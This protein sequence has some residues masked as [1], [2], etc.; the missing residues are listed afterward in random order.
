MDNSFASGESDPLAGTW[1]MRF[2]FPLYCYSRD[3]NNFILNQGFIAY[4]KTLVLSL[5]WIAWLQT[6]WNKYFE[7]WRVLDS[8][9]T[10]L[11]A[12]TATP[13]LSISC[14]FLTKTCSMNL[15]QP[16]VIKTQLLLDVCKKFTPGASLYLMCCFV[17]SVKRHEPFLL[18][19]IILYGSFFVSNH[20][21]I[22]LNWE[23]QLSLS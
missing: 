12:P 4:W 2:H 14:C 5:I 11:V 3:L 17:F 20:Y 23:I 21:Q 6:Q 10:V 18:S 19:Q 15:P 1:V 8:F 13:K 22:G 7:V 9:V 16:G